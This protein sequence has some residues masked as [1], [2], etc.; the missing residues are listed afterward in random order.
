MEQKKTRSYF[1]YAIGEILLVVIGILIALQINNW[2]EYRIERALERDLLTQLQSEYVSNLEQLDEKMNMRSD[3]ID[4][5]MNLIDYIDNPDKRD[6]DSTY[7]FIGRTIVGPTFDPIVNDIISSGRIQLIQN[8][9]LRNLLTRWTSD[10]IQITEE[11]EAWVDY[12]SQTYAPIL[13]KH[14][15][16]RTLMNRNWE[17]D[18][19]STFHLDRKMG[20]FI[21][22]GD[23]QNK[24]GHQQLLKDPEFESHIAYCLSLAILTNSQSLSLRN[25]II[26]ILALIKNDINQI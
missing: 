10:V 25:R 2:N 6:T 20:T 11:E 26:E 5:A 19:F 24:K 22:M 9:E 8:S 7:Y 23:S 3:M 1:L 15:S 16:M 21:D 13:R 14:I 17:S 18:L 4:A 12:R